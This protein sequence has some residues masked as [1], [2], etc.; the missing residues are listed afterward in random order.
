MIPKT[1]F[2]HDVGNRRATRRKMERTYGKTP[3]PL[4]PSFKSY[5]ITIAFLLGILVISYLIVDVAI[6]LIKVL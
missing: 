2:K 3:P 6:N 5:A 1:I 4:K